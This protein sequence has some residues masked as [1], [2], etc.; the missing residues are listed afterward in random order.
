MRLK[1]KNKPPSWYFGHKT[2]FYL[3]SFWPL[4]KFSSFD[5]VAP[6]VAEPIPTLWARCPDCL[7]NYFLPYELVAPT[8]WWDISYRISSLPRLFREP[9]P[10]VSSFCPDCLWAFSYRMNSLPQ[11]IGEPFLTLWPRCPDYLVS[12]DLVNAEF[13]V[14]LLETGKIIFL[15]SVKDPALSSYGSDP[16]Y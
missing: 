11:L 3:L 15:D 16:K 10:T 5:P 7:V 8:V 6:P 2:I 13:L 14:R 12:Q 9:F 1:R 4:E